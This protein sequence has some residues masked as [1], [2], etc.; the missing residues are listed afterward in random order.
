[1]WPLVR[2]T[3]KHRAWRTARPHDPGRPKFGSHK[4]G[5]PR[6][7]EGAIGFFGGLLSALSL[8]VLCL[9]TLLWAPVEADS[10]LA[11]L[12]AGREIQST[13]FL[14][15]S[16]QY[17]LLELRPTRS[18]GSDWISLSQNPSN[19]A[20]VAAAEALLTANGEGRL[21]SG[22]GGLPAVRALVR[23]LEGRPTLAGEVA[24]LVAERNLGR[25]AGGLSG[26]RLALLA[27]DLAWRYPAQ[28]LLEYALNSIYYGRLATG[29]NEGAWAYF[30][31]PAQELSL[32][33]VATLTVLGQD[34]NLA[35][36]P[37]E[38]EKARAG[39]LEQMA[40]LGWM[41]SPQALQAASQPVAFGPLEAV[42]NPAVAVF[43]RLAQA[44][45]ESEFS[46]AALVTSGSQ[47]TTSLDFPLQ[48]EALCAAQ[49]EAVW[50]AGAPS[51]VRP[52]RADGGNCASADLIEKLGEV[53]APGIDFGVAVLQPRTGTLLAYFPSIRDEALTDRRGEPGT[54]LLPFVYLAAFAQGYSPASAVL[55]VPSSAGSGPE[56][57]LPLLNPD[58]GYL[59][60][61]R[62]R[63]ALLDGRLA[64]S[65][66]VVKS[67]GLE[68]VQ[69]TL[70][71]MGLY[72]RPQDVPRDSRSLLLS[73]GNSSLLDLTRAYTIIADQ[74]TQAST[75]DRDSVG[76]IDQVVDRG[77][78]EILPGTG[79]PPV[80]VI[81]PGLAY[82]LEDVLSGTGLGPGAGRNGWSEGSYTGSSAAT[83][84]A[85]AF[86]LT[87]DF[88]VGVWARGSAAAGLDQQAALPLARAIGR[89]L[90]VEET[91]ESWTTPA[92]IT[93]LE[94]CDPS[95]LLPGKDC[96]NVASEVFLTG[97]EPRQV[98][99]YYQRLAVDAE[100]GRL[101]T[102]WTPPSLVQQKV[103]Q[104]PPAEARSWTPASGIPLVPQEYDTLPSSFPYSL[105]LHI[106]S[107]TPFSVVHGVVPVTGTAA[108]QSQAAYVLQAG[109][110]FYPSAWYLVNQAASQPQET[111]LGSWDTRGLEGLVALQLLGIGQD[112]HVESFAIPVTVD[113]VPPSLQWVVP[114]AGAVER[115]ARGGVAIVQIRAQDNLG[116][117]LVEFDLDGR[118]AQSLAQGPYSVRWSNLP[119]GTH[120]VTV[121]AVDLAG[122]ETEIGPLRLVVP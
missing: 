61:L 24:N 63:R 40:S 22:S 5:F 26:L 2:V 110:G 1:M 27:A 29:L 35:G 69:R 115:V 4:P 94:V 36:R 120:Q 62:A 15:R 88:V 95:G 76:L 39:L 86:F 78:Q 59:G 65:A 93:R 28:T 104:N 45:L 30:Q 117:A 92:D 38:L 37:E 18:Q 47:V 53:R 105:A 64:A 14:D 75:F 68:N 33:E 112:G 122:N 98:D 13:R 73:G 67:V 91:P 55:D 101:A 23:T 12:P 16:G 118:L 102:L 21:S 8:I 71:G 7:A 79:E 52:L 50:L 74:G 19:P 66:E 49:S 51:S 90:E 116:L 70:S 25:L 17:L 60:L 3:R 57:E 6:L 96:P 54:A 43:L 31:K 119:P 41:G 84:D 87:P 56:A 85:W 97:S 103:F 34:P 11:I 100:T 58:G 114:S 77:G 83:G 46:E 9:T 108:T 80:S 72:R 32:E 20:L 107:P 121:H 89:W 109:A 113:N 99:S 42:A 81:S 106:T 48:L 82:L 111:L 44:Q 10:S